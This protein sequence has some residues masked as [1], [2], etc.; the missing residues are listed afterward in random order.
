[1]PGRGIH[2]AS[3]KLD[4]YLNTNIEETKYC[5]KLDIQKFYP[6][7]NHEILKNLLRKKIK[8]KDLLIE[9]DK[10]IDSMKTVSLEHLNIS[11][12]L[13]EKSFIP[14]RGVPIGSYLS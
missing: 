12:E 9:L 11:S 5:L 7:I 8:D 13:K 6:N 10:I 14:G 3:K 4:K 1:M 2:Y